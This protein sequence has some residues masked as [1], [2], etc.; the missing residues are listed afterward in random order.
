MP[1]FFLAKDF[2]LSHRDW[3][4]IFDFNRLLPRS[5][6]SLSHA[7]K[8]QFIQNTSLKKMYKLGSQGQDRSNDHSLLTGKIDDKKKRETPSRL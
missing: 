1:R 6:L 7:V 4:V 8:L 5:P 2:F 3:K